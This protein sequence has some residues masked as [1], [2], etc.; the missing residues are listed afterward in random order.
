MCGVLRDERFS[1]SLFYHSV[2]Y[3]R[4]YFCPIPSLIRDQLEY[5][6]SVHLPSPNLQYLYTN[7]SAVYCNCMILLICFAGVTGRWDVYV[8]HALVYNTYNM[9]A[10]TC[11]YITS[12]FSL[13]C[14]ASIYNKA[15]HRSC[16]TPLYICQVLASAI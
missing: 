4:M 3:E 16:I 6:N 7:Y 12:F 5:R 11:N 2:S 14:N 15:C 9:Y 10:I 8:S 13:Y 1:C